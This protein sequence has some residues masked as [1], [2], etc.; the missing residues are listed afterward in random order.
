MRI[1]GIGCYEI[2]ERNVPLIRT[3]AEKITL[4]I[5]TWIV[6]GDEKRRHGGWKTKDSDE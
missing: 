1:R 5:L 4:L 2:R 3:S 6:I